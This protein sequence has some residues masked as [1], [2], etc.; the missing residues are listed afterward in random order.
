MSAP[1]WLVCSCVSL[2]FSWDT[3]KAVNLSCTTCF[4]ENVM[5]QPAA[6]RHR[7]CQHHSMAAA[8]YSRSSQCPPYRN[9]ALSV[10]LYALSAPPDIKRSVPDLPDLP[11]LPHTASD[12]L[13]LHCLV[14]PVQ[15]CMPQNI[16]HIS[17]KGSYLNIIPILVLHGIGGELSLCRRE[18]RLRSG[19]ARLNI[20]SQRGRRHSTVQLSLFASHG[21]SV[22][23][24]VQPCRC[25]GACRV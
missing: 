1:G 3:S 8:C 4:C 25:V 17:P 21:P 19:P 13:L 10:V 5:H 2:L 6:V 24:A 18:R 15:Q 20:L 12:A 22:A 9:A 16:G 23:H 11:T 7:Q 14:Q